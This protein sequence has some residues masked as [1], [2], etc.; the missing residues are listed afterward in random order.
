MRSRDRADN[1]F[2]E[3]CEEGGSSFG[4]L[5]EGQLHE[6][7]SNFQRIE[8]FATARFG[9][10]LVLDGFVMLTTRDNFI[11]H[12]ML[13]HPALLTHPDPKRV[14]IVGGGDCGCLHEVLKHETV[15]GADMVELDERVTRT[16][17]RFF[18]ELCASNDD[19]RANL[20]FGDGI[21]W[22]ASAGPASYDIIIVD[23]TDPIGQAARLF[24]ADFYHACRRAL[25]DDGILIVQSESPLLHLQLIRSIR[26]EMTRAG[27]SSVRTLQF[28][29]CCY[30][31][32]WWS[33]TMAGS[34]SALEDFRAGE[35]D[36]LDTRYYN[37][38]VHRGALA[39][40]NFL[41]SG[42]SKR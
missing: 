10:L 7:Q 17:E 4:L 19:P 20:N 21:E 25:T 33:A 39:M 30:P 15:R 2:V 13:T 31:S 28:P 3:R 40:P 5:L 8:V 42:L 27:F 6:E 29:Q 35:A 18:P 41:R 1:W 36:R 34:G 11:Y 26:D 32:G 9:R 14:L 38:A 37:A 22:V 24:R 23:S 16:S 12:E